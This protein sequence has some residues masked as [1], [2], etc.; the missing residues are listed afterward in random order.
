MLFDS[1]SFSLISFEFPWLS[2][3]HGTMVRTMAPWYHDT[4]EPWYHGTMVPWYHGTMVPWY[5]GS[6]VPWY[7]G[8]MV[9]WYVPWY[10]GSK[11]IKET[12]RKSREMREPQRKSMTIKPNQIKLNRRKPQKI[13]EWVY[14]SCFDEPFW[15]GRSNSPHPPPV[16]TH[17]LTKQKC[18]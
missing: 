15:L 14:V 3:S 11:A 6:M 7:H 10:H 9:P 13:K 5:N 2:W 12:H 8:S 4:M 18:L 16:R 17:V 1:A